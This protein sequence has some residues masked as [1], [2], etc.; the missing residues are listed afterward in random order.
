MKSRIKNRRPLSELTEE[1]VRQS[2]ADGVCGEKLALEFGIS[3]ST[4]RNHLAE[5]AGEKVANELC[6]ALS[7]LDAVDSEKP[8]E[9]IIRKRQKTP[10][11]FLAPEIEP[12][13]ALVNDG[14]IAVCGTLCLDAFAGFQ[15]VEEDDYREETNAQVLIL[16]DVERHYQEELDDTLLEE[17]KAI[18]RLQARF[19]ELLN[20]RD[21]LRQK[22]ADAAALIKALHVERSTL[23]ERIKRTEENIGW[24][25]P[26]AIGNARREAE[27]QLTRMKEFSG[28]RRTQAEARYAELQVKVESAESDLVDAKVKLVRLKSRLDEVEKELRRHNEAAKIIGEDIDFYDRRIEE[29]AAEITRLNRPHFYVKRFEEGVVVACHHYD[30][31]DEVFDSAP[32]A[33][34]ARSANLW[35]D[36]LN[37]VAFERGEEIPIDVYMSAARILM[38][39]TKLKPDE[40]LITYEANTDDLKELVDMFISD[41]RN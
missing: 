31:F 34:T 3:T 33:S 25:L 5:V 32:S 23:D 9:P 16:R 26:N 11:V 15:K 40:Y 19:Q 41:K 39:A 1:L 7:H 28:K 36:R 2:I 20:G 14:K 37:E 35:G 4:L 29:T 6:F 8:K 38:V 21:I 13:P 27:R 18:E 12:Q 17:T 24:G 10:P 30:G 22:S